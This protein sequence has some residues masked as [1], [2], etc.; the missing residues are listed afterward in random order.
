M[1][2]RKPSEMD[3]HPAT[4]RGGWAPGSDG[5]AR[6]ASSSDY[7]DA[8]EGEHEY[9]EEPAPRHHRRHRRGGHRRGGHHRAPKYDDWDSEAEEDADWQTSGHSYREAVS[10]S[11]E[12]HPR[13]WYNTMRQA[14]GGKGRKMVLPKGRPLAMPV[15]KVMPGD[16]RA[17]YD[18]VHMPETRL[19]NLRGSKKPLVTRI[20]L[21]TG[22]DIG[23][24]IGTRVTHA[25]VAG[26]PA[27]V[28]MQVGA[29]ICSAD[30]RT[31]RVM[32]TK[33]AHV[34]HSSNADRPLAGAGLHAD[35][36]M[37]VTGGALRPARVCASAH[38][39]SGPAMVRAMSTAQRRALN[40]PRTQMEE[41]LRGT[42][43]D[44]MSV[45]L[46]VP[47][48]ASG[49]HVATVKTAGAALLL[50]NMANVQARVV[51]R[52]GDPLTRKQFMPSGSDYLE[53]ARDDVNG[54]L[55]EV[56]ADTETGG[57]IEDGDYL[58]VTLAPVDGWPAATAGHFAMHA[59]SPESVQ[60]PLVRPVLELVTTG[61]HLFDLAEAEAL[62]KTEAG[63]V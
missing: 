49:A 43:D 21:E 14:M 2:S 44:P 19:Q 53:V 32:L 8:S 20:P 48:P 59:T 3:S 42:E 57:R 52:G 37:L 5:D 15:G 50:R 38:S 16:T 40:F 27:G 28:A 51:K 26:M 63:Q 22:G 46:H 1:S 30:G 29:A 39:S 18:L 12:D 31:K 11:A 60:N 47:A 56:Y 61:V 34:A 58:E 35:H 9:V 33:S 54:L 6:D 45:H 25:E 7:D 41:S 62:G 13:G 10:Q 36:Q 24:L 55:D 17:R 4:R 23:A